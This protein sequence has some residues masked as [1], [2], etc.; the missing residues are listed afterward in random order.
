MKSFFIVAIVHSLFSFHHPAQ[1]DIKYFAND[2]TI[3]H[4][5][6]GKVNEWSAQKFETDPATQLKYAID[7][8]KRYLYLVLSIPGFG[9]QMKIVR[10]HNDP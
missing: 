6:D 2:T 9:E 5:L 7:N 4:L 10:Q 8:D 3:N 1:A